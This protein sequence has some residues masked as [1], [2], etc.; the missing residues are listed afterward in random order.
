MWQQLQL[1]ALIRF[2]MRRNLMICVLAIILINPIISQPAHAFAVAGEKCT[3]AGS[4]LIV[5]EWTR[6]FTCVKIGK[7]LVWNS[8]VL[9]VP[10]DPDWMKSYNEIS[11]TSR[12]SPNLL[13]YKPT[14]V[15][16]NVDPLL[17]SKLL[18]YQN[19]AS[20]YWKIQG[21][22]SPYPIHV[23]ILSEK[24]ESMY[25]E[26][27]KEYKI[28]CS[29]CNSTQWLSPDF[30]TKF[31]GTVLVENFDSNAPGTSDPIGLTIL[32]VIGTKNVAS[33]P[34]WRSDL[35]T[36]F[37]HEYEHLIQFSELR[38]FKNMSK[39]ACWFTEGFAAF[40]ED[41]IYF[42][43][44][45]EKNKIMDLRFPGRSVD[46]L[47]N[48]RNGRLWWANKSVKD[49]FEK[50]NVPAL[51]NEASLNK[52]FSITDIKNSEGCR[53]TDNGRGD[54]QFISQY[55]YED[56]GAKAFLVL[57]QNTNKNGDWNSGFK[58][59]TGVEYAQWLNNRV[60][61][62]LAKTLS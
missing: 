46:W 34:A 50:N 42:E 8:G 43:N 56:F 20:S 23:L 54:G 19:L 59:T 16:P 36:A 4:S 62:S 39:I 2:S 61:P 35:S 57:L 9:I 14:V 12:I 13:T 22:E 27:A 58:E 18:T 49:V 44:V 51:V 45:K 40:F 55:F 21:F 33:N 3:K 37:T 1:W 28:N 30:A 47:S 60:I 32:Y 25:I 7:K 24:D 10:P 52:F 6:K 29:V 15:S 5:Q 48:R 26:Y 53:L 41:A 31:Q 11:S 17:V 38:G